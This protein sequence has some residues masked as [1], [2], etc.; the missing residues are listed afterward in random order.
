MDKFKYPRLHNDCID[1]KV[2]LQDNLVKF[3]YVAMRTESPKCLDLSQTVDLLD[4]ETGELY[5]Y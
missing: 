4:T 2:Y 3:K 1:H 5:W